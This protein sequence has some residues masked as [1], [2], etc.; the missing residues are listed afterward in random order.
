MPYKRKPQH[1]A[2]KSISS[3]ELERGSAIESGSLIA[4]DLEVGGTASVTKT[5]SQNPKAIT[6]C[7]IDNTIEIQFSLKASSTTGGADF[8][9]FH[10]VPVPVG[11]TL[12]LEGEEI[13]II[14]KPNEGYSLNFRIESASGTPQANILLKT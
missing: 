14:S 8:L 7:N 4:M 3:R 5:I 2:V 11:A 9:M 12:V 13:S 6:V 10:K 1:D